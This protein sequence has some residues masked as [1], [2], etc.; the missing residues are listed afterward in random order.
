[1]NF[2]LLKNSTVGLAICLAFG[3]SNILTTDITESK[4]L[5]DLSFAVKAVTSPS[6]K[7]SMKPC[8]PPP[9][10]PPIPVQVLN[11]IKKENPSLMTILDSMKTLAPEEH[12]T[13]MIELSKQYPQYFKAPPPNANCSAIPN[14]I[15][16]SQAPSQKTKAP[17]NGISQ[18]P[19]QPQPEGSVIPLCPPPPPIPKEIMEKI[20]IEEPNL[21]TV[22]ES[23]KTLAPEEHKA[24]MIELSKQYPQYFKA[25]PELPKDGSCPPPPEKK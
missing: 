22:L 4:N 3:C 23:M 15:Q 17:S 5:D 16:Q 18:P 24:K 19:S 25:L 7:P 12:R 2:R 9:P 13:K 20:K 10:P 1:M 21:M 14:G 6:V 11:K 8:P